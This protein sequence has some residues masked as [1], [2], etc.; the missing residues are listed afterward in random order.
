MLKINEPAVRIV[1]DETHY[2]R[3]LESFDGPI[4][5]KKA[6]GL[7]LEVSEEVNVENLEELIEDTSAPTKRLSQLRFG[8]L[9]PT[10]PRLNRHLPNLQS[11]A[12]MAPNP[13]VRISPVLPAVL[14]NSPPTLQSPV[15]M[16]TN[17]AVPILPVQ[18]PVFNHPPP[19]IP[20]FRRSL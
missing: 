10:D 3:E 14:S 8:F 12:P 7:G 17:P 2:L 4:L 15:P 5:F 16:A 19:M 6:K 20:T 9:I 13:V 1:Q 18:L 11:P